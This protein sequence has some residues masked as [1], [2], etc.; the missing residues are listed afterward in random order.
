MPYGKSQRHVPAKTTVQV[1]RPKAERVGDPGRHQRS[2]AKPCGACSTGSAG[3]AARTS[4]GRPGTVP[5]THP[6]GHPWSPR[7]RTPR[8]PDG[9][10]ASGAWCRAPGRRR[11]ARWLP[12]SP[13]RRA[14][15]SAGPRDCSR[16]TERTR[17]SGARP[18]Q[19][20]RLRSGLRRFRGR[21]PVRTGTVTQPQRNRRV[22]TCRPGG[23]GR[24]WPRYGPAPPAPAQRAPPP[25]RPP[26]SGLSAPALAAALGTHPAPAARPAPPP[27]A[28]RPGGTPESCFIS[29]LGRGVSAGVDEWTCAA[30]VCKEALG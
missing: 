10:R 24:R 17:H 5:C 29:G 12:S 2:E 22:G 28:A 15:S 1:P 18:T 16:S 11:R 26:G 4:C 14:L 23:N 19:R 30:G 9:R 3:K 6:S 8:H 25:R 21:G 27:L 13:T 20:P 7:T